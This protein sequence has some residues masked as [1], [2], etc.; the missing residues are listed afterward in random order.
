[1]EVST[2]MARRMVTEFGMSDKIGHLALSQQ[3]GPVFLGRDLADHKN[4]SEEMATIV[5]N[6]VKRI[7]EEQYARAKKLLSDNLDKV[8][9]VAQLLLD[10]EVLSAQEV[11]AAIGL[12]DE[13]NPSEA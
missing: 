6:E 2:K 8:K 13:I 9:I 4:Y 11:K 7:M 12:S 5:D 3:T 1:L 10:K